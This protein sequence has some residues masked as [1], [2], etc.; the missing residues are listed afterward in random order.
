MLG[1]VGFIAYPDD[2]PENAVISQNQLGGGA[3][4]AAFKALGFG[5]LAPFLISLFISVSR[6][7]TV[8]F[9]YNSKDFTIDTFLLMGLIEFSYFID[10]HNSFG[11]THFQ[12]IV[13]VLAS[14]AQITGTL[15]MIYASTYGLAGSSSA[16]VQSQGVVHVL[17]ASI[18][19]N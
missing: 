9:G 17:L 15:L 14:V 19:L 13:G 10:Y 16:M 1:C 2:K 5:L 12:L 3:E 4:S 7:W 11:Y 8:N 6:Y 18:F